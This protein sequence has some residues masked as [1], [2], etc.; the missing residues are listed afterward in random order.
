[1]LSSPLFFAEKNKYCQ[2]L[3]GHVNGLAYAS[4]LMSNESL[5]KIA[6]HHIS[7]WMF[8]VYRNDVFL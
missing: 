8:R 6:L 1:M 7:I 4:G 5:K 2:F 3:S